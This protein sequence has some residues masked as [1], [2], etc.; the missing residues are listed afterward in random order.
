MHHYQHMGF[1]YY[2]FE[3]NFPVLPLDNELAKEPPAAPLS[4]I[5]YY[6]TTND[7]IQAAR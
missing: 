4:Q 7:V 5:A 1:L 2:E 6:R 3:T